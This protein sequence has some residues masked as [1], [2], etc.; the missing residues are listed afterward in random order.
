MIAGVEP[1]LAAY[2]LR[3]DVAGVPVI[4]GLSFET[5][6]AQVLVLGAARA[7]FEG[8]SGLRPVV[9][10]GLRI[11]GM[12]PVRAIR[13]GIVACAPLDPPM[14][15]RWTV[16]QYVRWSAQLSGLP[17]DARRAKCADALHAMQLEA[18]AGVRLSA[19]P[20]PVRR[21]AAL[22]AA[23]ATGARSLLVE[24]PVVG[25]PEEAARPFARV[26][27]RALKG[28]RSVLF[29]GRIPLESPLALAAE[30]AVLIEGS[31]VASQGNPAEIASA[32]EVISLRVQG[33]V[34]AFARA[35]EAQGGHASV[36]DNTVHPARMRVELGPL[37]SRDLLRIAVDT[38]AVIF[39]LRPLA[40]AFA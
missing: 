3:I 21:G 22:A 4:D 8:F 27:S 9:R 29:A 40:R 11:Q 1:M 33:D 37:A 30:E 38:R 25:L 26:L 10:G 18:M 24:D 5:T 36:T 19:A 7:L 13:A 2:G 12:T 28:L 6:G 35:V 34:D 17:R 23:L 15:G 20:L 31:R 39:E 32:Q 16:G 14:P